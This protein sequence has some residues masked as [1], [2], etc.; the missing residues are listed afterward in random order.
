MK[1][2]IEN[3][4]KSARLATEVTEALESLRPLFE[5]GDAVYSVAWLTTCLAVYFYDSCKSAGRKKSA[6]HSRK[7][8]GSKKTAGRRYEK[9]RIKK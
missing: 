8:A 2:K 6:E 7:S 9:R 4:A 5:G 3:I 1:T